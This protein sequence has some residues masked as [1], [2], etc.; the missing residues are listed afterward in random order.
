MLLAT[1][2]LGLSVSLEMYGPTGWLVPWASSAAFLVPNGEVTYLPF[3]VVIL[4]VAV[5][6]SAPS[7][8]V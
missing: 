7:D 6:I 3:C 8:T 5:C 1:K 2:W 4:Y